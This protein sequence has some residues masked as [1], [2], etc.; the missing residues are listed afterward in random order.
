MHRRGDLVRRQRGLPVAAEEIA[1]GQPPYPAAGSPVRSRHPAPAAAARHPRPGRHCRDCRPGSRGSAPAP[2]R[3]G[4][5]PG[6]AR[7]TRAAGAASRSAAQVTGRRCGGGHRDP[8]SRPAPAAL[9]GPAAAGRPAASR[10]RPRASGR[11]DVRPAGQQQRRRGRR[12]QQGQRFGQA[13][14][15]A[16]GGHAPPGSSSRHRRAAPSCRL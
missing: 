1:E 15:S 14:R 12:G 8:R 6:A 3:P 9:R 5:P 11:V 16:I 4:P 7:R 10:P 2:R 13:R